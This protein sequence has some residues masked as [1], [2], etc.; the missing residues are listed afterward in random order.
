VNQTIDPVF[1]A[2]LR[3]E[4]VA[5]PSAGPRRIRHRA[6]LITAAAI[7]T[8]ALGG[9]VVAV[10]GLRPADQVATAPLSPPVIVNGVGPAK[11]A[12]PAAPTN[13][14]Y[15]RL[16][17]TCFDGTRCNTPGGGIEGPDTGT[18]RV[19]RD[20]LPLSATL[21]PTNAQSLPPLD[22]ADGVPIEVAPG[23]HWRLY[24]VYT[25][26]LNPVSAPVANG[27]T[28][29]IPSTLDIPDLVPVIATNG[30]AGWA[31]YGLLTDQG[32]PELTDVG[33]SQAPIAVY[34]ADG[35]TVI[36]EADV[37]QPYHPTDRLGLSP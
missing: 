26:S 33:T 17:L 27:K 19:Q 37:S 5:L 31:D 16:E 13:A 4:L 3:R 35:K 18:P 30:R 10:A 1:S 2:A 36:G 29:G 25:D 28:L 23:T 22:P 8:V 7:T 20:A 14:R 11:V 15:A 6:A 9:G 24:A 32:R 12:L 34:G 21:D